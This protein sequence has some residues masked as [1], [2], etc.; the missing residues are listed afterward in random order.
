MET[1]KLVGPSLTAGGLLTSEELVSF[2]CTK[3]GRF[4]PGHAEGASHKARPFC[5]P[6]RIL[7]LGC[8]DGLV[9]SEQLVSFAAAKL[10]SFIRGHAEE[11]SHKARLFCT[12]DRIR[13]CDLWRR[14]PTL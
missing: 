6:D 10:G 7:N 13:T 9:A 3:L 4:I 11:A 5:T 14:R 8:S 1:G 12:P 2:A